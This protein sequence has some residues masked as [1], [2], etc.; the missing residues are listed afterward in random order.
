MRNAW[1][2]KDIKDCSHKGNTD[3]N[4]ILNLVQEKAKR[5]TASRAKSKSATNSSHLAQE[6][7]DLKEIRRM[8]EHNIQNWSEQLSLVSQS[9]KHITV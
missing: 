7:G 2:K 8:R 5:W 1:R 4:L 9:T 6:R 3:W